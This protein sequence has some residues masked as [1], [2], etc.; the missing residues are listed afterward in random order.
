MP[1]LIMQEIVR[2]FGAA[3]PVEIAA[4][5]ESPNN[6]LDAKRPREML[7][8]QQSAVLNALVM[9]FGDA[10]PATTQIGI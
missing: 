2:K 1:V 10:A 9:H 5:I 6:Y 4:W 8:T 3:S 7:R